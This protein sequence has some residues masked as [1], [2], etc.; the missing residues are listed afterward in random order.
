MLNRRHH[1]HVSCTADAAPELLDKLALFFNRQAFLTYDLLS[2]HPQ[3]PS[4]SHRCIEQCDYLILLITDSYGE[5]NN[6]GVSQ[7]HLSYVYAKTK[8]K[9]IL[10]LMKVH[11]ESTP[12]PQKLHDFITLIAQHITY[13]RYFDEQTDLSALLAKAYADLKM[14][15]PS[16]GWQH[17]SDSDN[18]NDDEELNVP[19]KTKTSA[20]PNRS[21]DN[22]TTVASA[23]IQQTSAPIDIDLDKS[24][25][26]QYTAHAYA[27]GNLS[28]VK[29]VAY[30]RWFNILEALVNTPMPFSRYSLHRCLNNI[31]SQTAEQ[32][33][34]DSMPQ[35]HAVS[36]CQVIAS[37]LEKVQKTLIY[38]NLITMLP[39]SMRQ[40]REMWEVTAEAKDLL[41]KKQLSN[42]GVVSEL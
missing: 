5:L 37:D 1:I 38:A 13:T 12:L 15:Y 21:E 26:L 8:K 41:K 28:E 31:V 42:L 11:P 4:Y 23:P 14:N 39:T 36:R 18:D 22:P 7:M 30:V 2:R 29:M 24:I 33:I 32:G 40:F 9:P 17:A 16:L 27:E 19:T 25:T 3:A 10:A 34:K 20:L 35:V 6:T